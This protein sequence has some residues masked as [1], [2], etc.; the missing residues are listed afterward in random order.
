MA[1]VDVNNKEFERNMVSFLSELEDEWKVYLLEA[2]DEGAT[3]L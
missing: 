2:D 3:L 1:L